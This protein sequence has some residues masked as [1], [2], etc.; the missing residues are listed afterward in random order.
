MNT[1]TSVGAGVPPPFQTG[2]VVKDMQAALR[3]WTEIV[4][5]GPFFVLRASQWEALYYKDR[6]I[7]LDSRVALGQWGNL[8]L[9]FIEQL[10][11]C[12]SPYKTFADQG[13]EGLHHFGSMVDDLDDAVGRL[14]AAGRR[15]VYWG[16]AQGGVRFAYL[17]EDEH[18]G[19]M[20]ELIEHG[21]AID[22]LMA[23]IRDAARNWNGSD[24][25]RELG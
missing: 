19:A 13:R 1:F 25:I 4:G 7:E 2:F 12:P 21:E 8:Q 17:V 20:I 9:E 15:K 5:A 18:P 6:P 14:E 22:G 23:M 3:Y 24:P 16:T 11:D 10:N